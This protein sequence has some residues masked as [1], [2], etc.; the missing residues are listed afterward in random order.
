MTKKRSDERGA[1]VVQWNR[2]EYVAVTR[3]RKPAPLD[4]PICEVDPKHASKCRCPKCEG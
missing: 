4:K 2:G 1:K 3:K